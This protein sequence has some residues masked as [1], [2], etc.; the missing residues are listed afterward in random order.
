MPPL[1]FDKS[2]IFVFL[3]LTIIRNAITTQYIFNTFTVKNF[4]NRVTF[5]TLHTSNFSTYPP[6]KDYNSQKSAQGK[7]YDVNKTGIYAM[8][9]L[10]VVR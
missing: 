7:V 2:F 5:H 3:D 4:I 1:L 8:K 6:E 9:L 10:L